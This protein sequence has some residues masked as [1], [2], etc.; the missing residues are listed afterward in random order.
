MS[1]LLF[2]QIFMF[3]YVVLW[4]LTLIPLFHLITCTCI[5]SKTKQWLSYPSLKILLKRNFHESNDSYRK[6]SKLHD[7]D[8]NLIPFHFIFFFTVVRKFK[9]RNA[10][11]KSL[12]PLHYHF[13]RCKVKGRWVCFFSIK[14]SKWYWNVIC[15]YNSMCRSSC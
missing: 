4:L 6:F 10:L 14:M 1:N 5:P 15:K 13:L 3:V 2:L 8:G 11:K 12:Y 7:E 9:D